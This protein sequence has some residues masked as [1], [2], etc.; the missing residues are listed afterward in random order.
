[1]C[2]SDNF[3]L[4]YWQTRNLGSSIFWSSTEALLYDKWVWHIWASITRTCC[5]PTTKV[6]VRINILIVTIIPSDWR[7]QSSEATSRRRQ[8]IFGFIECNVIQ[9]ASDRRLLLSCFHW[10]RRWYIYNLLEVEFARS[11]SRLLTHRI[12]VTQ[13]INKWIKR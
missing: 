6:I 13:F 1:M 3:S 9:K 8:L 7:Q 5:N 4:K 12:F 10:G 2:A 11:D